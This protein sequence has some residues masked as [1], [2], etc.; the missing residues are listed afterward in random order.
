MRRRAPQEKKQLSLEKDRRNIYGEAPHG[1]RKSIPL[2]KKLRNRANRH[3]QELALPSEPMTLDTDQAD[4]VESA[5]RH[6]AP[7]VWRKCP[8]GPL[9]EVIGNKQRKRAT[10][11]AERS[12]IVF[13]KTPKA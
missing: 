10:P 9:K 5:L 12:R 13:G 3:S 4:E 6:K 1:A 11:K 2:R 7:Q 8:D